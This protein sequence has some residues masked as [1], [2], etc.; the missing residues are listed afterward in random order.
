[1]SETADSEHAGPEAE[2]SYRPKP[3]LWR[4]GLKSES[5]PLL[6]AVGVVLALLVPLLMAFPWIEEHFLSSPASPIIVE[7]VK[8]DVSDDSGE[9]VR[10]FRHAGR[11]ANG[12]QA[13]FWSERLHRP[14]ERLAVM[15]SR[16]RITHRVRL[17]PPYAGEVATP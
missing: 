1:M 6:I 16:G 14:G 15:A 17:R 12:E 8:A 10:V 13:A 9:K 3:P 11:L 5:S 7:V 4:S 2:G